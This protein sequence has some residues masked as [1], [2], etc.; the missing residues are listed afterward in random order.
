MASRQIGSVLP[1]SLTILVNAYRKQNLKKLMKITDKQ[2]T[3]TNDSKS[4][5][6]SGPRLNIF[7]LCTDQTSIALSVLICLI[8]KR[9]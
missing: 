7:S 6:E 2:Y 4:I 3:K 1:A 8:V 9:K 5:N